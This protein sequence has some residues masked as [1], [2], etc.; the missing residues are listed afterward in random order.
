MLNPLLTVIVWKE[1]KKELDI[2]KIFLIINSRVKEYY[3]IFT[4]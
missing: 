4:L 2:L 1:T 3:Y